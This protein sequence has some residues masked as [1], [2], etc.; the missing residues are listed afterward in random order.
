[1]IGKYK[2]KKIIVMLL[3]FPIITAC[4]SEGA[5]LGL[6]GA[7]EN[8]LA[9]KVVGAKS[10]NPNIKHGQIEK[11]L[12]TIEGEG[13]ETPITAEFDG[14]ASEGVIDGVPT[15]SDRKITIEAINPNKNIIRAGEILGVD[16]DDGLTEVSVEMQSVPIFANLA[17]GASV[18]N[19]RLTFELFADPNHKVGVEEVGVSTNV[20]EINLDAATG[21]G[22]MKPP[23]ISGGE[24]EFIVRD[25]ETNRISKIKLKVSDGVKRKPAPF[26]AGQTLVS[27]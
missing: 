26:V 1:M 18:E 17:D 19:T 6:Y 15:G 20:S 11:Y 22:V 14:N 9:I 7:S 2:M 25:M 12:V 24:H 8:L 21:I 27:F 10:F 3:G 16:V 4:S 5:K 23:L 13:I